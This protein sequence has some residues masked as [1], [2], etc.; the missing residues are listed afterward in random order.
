MDLHP[1]EEAAQVPTLMAMGMLR[2]A[3]TGMVLHQATTATHHRATT[4]ATRR[5]WD[6]ATVAM[7]ILLRVP[8]APIRDIQ[9][10]DTAATIPRPAVLLVLF[11]AAAMA[12]RRPRQALKAE[13]GLTDLHASGQ[14]LSPRRASAPRMKSFP[15]EQQRLAA[16]EAAAAAVAAK[17]P[18]PTGGSGG[19]DTFK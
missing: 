3:P 6:M 16:A 2:T 15:H 19:G 14:L 8:M 11:Q 1:P 9:V 13:G 10:M 12:H 4:T 5:R 17:K 7:G 18:L